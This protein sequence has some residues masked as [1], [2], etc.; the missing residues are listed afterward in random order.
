MNTSEK[1]RIVAYGA[2]CAFIFY[3]LSD[4]DIHGTFRASP[5]QAALVNYGP[6]AVKAVV[7]AHCLLWCFL[8]SSTYKAYRL[9]YLLTGALLLAIGRL[10]LIA[11]LIVLYHNT[12]FS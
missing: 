8:S 1:L 9:Y 5:L 3:Y 2:I 6:S 12:H 10:T 7:L 11:Y 4:A